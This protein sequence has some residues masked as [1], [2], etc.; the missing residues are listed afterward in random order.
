M[1]A[2]TCRV[3][4][5]GPGWSRAI[6]RCLQS[7]FALSTRLPPDTGVTAHSSPCE[8]AVVFPSRLKKVARGAQELTPAAPGPQPQRSRRKALSPHRHP[9][10]RLTLQTS[11]HVIG[12]HVT[13]SCW[14]KGNH[15]TCHSKIRQ[16]GPRS[17]AR[18]RLASACSSPCAGR[19]PAAGTARHKRRA[20]P[21]V[22]RKHLHPEG[23]SERG[24]S[25][26]LPQ[27]ATTTTCALIVAPVLPS[28]PPRTRSMPT[29]Q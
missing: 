15:L 28:A 25:Q 11:S 16:D 24:G 9:P 27:L 17:M 29:T 10:H 1:R 20:R 23:G 22:C 14:E 3:Q 26:L 12:S 4:S 2:T 6:S 7:P 5:R 18:S 21:G 13:L 8:P 19:R